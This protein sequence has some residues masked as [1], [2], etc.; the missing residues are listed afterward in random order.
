[1]GNQC[2]TPSAVHPSDI[3]SKKK[4]VRSTDAPPSVGS[5]KPVSVKPSGDKSILPDNSSSLSEK[6]AVSLES[7]VHQAFSLARS[8]DAL[9]SLLSH[10][11]SRKA[12]AN[13]VSPSG[14]ITNTPGQK[15]F[16]G[17]GVGKVCILISP[18]CPVV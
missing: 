6:G 1:M 7:F 14:D 11:K 8:E 13:F 18:L 9:S 4:S 15:P 2:S 17:N 10:K 12:F 3:P 16:D 5:A